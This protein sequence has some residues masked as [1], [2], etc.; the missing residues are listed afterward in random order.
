MDLNMESM[1]VLL[2]FNIIIDN[3]QSGYIGQTVMSQR[4]LIATANLFNPS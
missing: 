1:H 3:H 2:D 4:A